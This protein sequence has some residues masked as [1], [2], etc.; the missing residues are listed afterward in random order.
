[1]HQR[2]GRGDRA[3][4]TDAGTMKNA[5]HD[6]AIPTTG[7]AITKVLPP[8]SRFSRE[9]GHGLKKQAVLDKLAAFFE[10]YFGLA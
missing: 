7:T 1:R 3:A 6:G 8:G 4:G 9:N 5:F 2:A 10:C